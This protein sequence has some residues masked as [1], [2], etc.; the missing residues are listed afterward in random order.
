[1]KF[2]LRYVENLAK[3]GWGTGKSKDKKTIAEIAVEFEELREGYGYYRQ[4]DA[5]RV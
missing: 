2:K 1:M 4:Y 5:G 3:N